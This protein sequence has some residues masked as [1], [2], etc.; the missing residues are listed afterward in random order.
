MFGFT[1]A[2]VCIQEVYAPSTLYSAQNTEIA[3]A[4]VC[5]REGIQDLRFKIQDCRF[6]IEDSRFKID[7]LRFKI[8]D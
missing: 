8:Q 2:D 7:D 3:F 5:T 4:N 1:I 6:K